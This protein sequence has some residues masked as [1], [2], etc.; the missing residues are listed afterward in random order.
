MA[1]GCGAFDT[2]IGRC[3]SYIWRKAHFCLYQKQVTEEEEEDEKEEDDEEEEK[4]RFD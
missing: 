4:E 1:F 3:G 2:L